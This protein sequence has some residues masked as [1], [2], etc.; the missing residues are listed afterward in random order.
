[1]LPDDLRAIRDR[2]KRRLEQVAV[3]AAVRVVDIAQRDV[4]SGGLMRVDTGFL[5]NS[6][7]WSIDRPPSGPSDPRSDPMPTPGA[8]PVLRPGQ[9]LYWGW[10]ASYAAPRE[11]ED[12]FLRVALEQW[13][14]IVDEVTRELAR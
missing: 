12:G 4:G 7:A 11:A 2:A 1:M 14:R 13:P 3:V 9:T 8:A 6:G 5:R 10:T